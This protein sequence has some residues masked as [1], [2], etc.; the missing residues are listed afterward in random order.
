M[1]AIGSLVV[2]AVVDGT[3][4]PAAKQVSEFAQFGLDGVGLV[5]GAVRQPISK[6]VT[7]TFLGSRSQADAHLKAAALLIGTSVNIQR[8]EGSSDSVSDCV[9]K[10]V[11]VV[12][13]VACS[14]VA[15]SA[16]KLILS[17]ELYT[18]ID[19]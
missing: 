18:P 17:W 9:I 13:S 7:I 1:P 12:E 4:Q 19:W 8:D 11:T 6:L 5:V 2:F 15:S 3:L 14:G 16:W 10:N